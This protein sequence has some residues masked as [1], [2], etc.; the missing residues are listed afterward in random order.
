MLKFGFLV[1]VLMLSG[2][3]LFGPSRKQIAREEAGQCE[4]YGFTPGTQ[5]FSECFERVDMARVQEN[6]ARRNIVFQ[7]SIEQHEYVAPQTSYPRYP[8]LPTFP[9]LGNQSSY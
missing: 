7:H 9:T 3:A 1:S 2:C 5:Q 6:N 4:G 8:S